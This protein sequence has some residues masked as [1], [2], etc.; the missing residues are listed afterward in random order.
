VNLEHSL[1]IKLFL[2]QGGRLAPTAEARLLHEEADY[3]VKGMQRLQRLAA[4]IR[5]LE[6]GRLI[7]GAYPA[8]A[9][10]VLPRFI[11]SFVRQHPQLYLSLM[12]E[13][14]VRIA[15]L[16]ASKQMDIGLMAMPS[17]DPALT[18][19]LIYTGKSVCVLP[20]DHPLARQ[21]VVCASDLG[22]EPF[23]ALGREDG[24]RQ[25]VERSFE[26]AGILPETRMEAYFTDSACAF[27]AEGLG[28]AIVDRL[29]A[30]RWKGQIAILPYEPTVPCHVYLVRNKTHVSSLMQETFETSLQT[31]LEEE[32]SS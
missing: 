13:A 21:G 28:V 5:Q 2:R 24:S 9:S 26:N 32:F 20:L 27:V 23:I 29:S 12:P 15:E 22:S 25:A 17:F 1:K 11:G 14:S 16:V 3:V 6:A 4:D 10:I 18:C 19:E 8:L 31:Y 30:E 7:V